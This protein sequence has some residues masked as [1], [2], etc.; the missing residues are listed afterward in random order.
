MRSWAVA[1]LEQWSVNRPRWT[2]VVGTRDRDDG[3]QTP[4]LGEAERILAYR[5]GRL[6]LFGQDLFGE[7]AWDILLCGYVANRKGGACLIKDVEAIT[8]LSSAGIRRW[9][10]LLET[11][12][13]VQANEAAFAITLDAEAR[14]NSLF[15]RHRPTGKE[16]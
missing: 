3:A 10:A 11:R 6:E 12:G 14:L 9:L 7:P 13:L 16:S 8:R 15:K 2:K 1:L 4:F 5:E